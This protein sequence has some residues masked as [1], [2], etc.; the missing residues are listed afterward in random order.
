MYSFLIHSLLPLLAFIAGAVA[1]RDIN[2]PQKAFFLQV[3]IYVVYLMLLPNIM[4]LQYSVHYYD[5]PLSSFKPNTHPYNNIHLL[6]ETI[7]LLA[8]MYEYIKNYLIASKWLFILFIFSILILATYEWQTKGFDSYFSKTDSLIS[9]IMTIISGYALY[10]VFSTSKSNTNS[11]ADKWILSGLFIYFSASIPFISTFELLFKY[12][13][14]DV[15]KNL[16][17]YI[18][19]TSANI[20][21]FCLAIGF[22][23]IIK[24]HKTKLF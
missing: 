1:L 4:L 6:I 16:H 3:L 17:H 7:V 2:K 18:I 19:L 24:Q 11:L 8:G 20:R 5:A 22:Y 23:I 21:Y 15:F 12:P 10:F 14:S 13:E 9:L